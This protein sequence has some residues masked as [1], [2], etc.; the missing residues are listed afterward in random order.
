MPKVK[1][2]TAAGEIIA[3]LRADF[4]PRT[5]EAILSFLPMQYE[6]ML[7]CWGEEIFFFLPDSL[8]HIDYENAKTELEIGDVAYWPRDPA[9]C[10]FFGRTPLSKGSKPVAAGPVNVIGKV[11]EGMEIL[12]KLEDGDLI[13][14]EKKEE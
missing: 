10:I 1:F 13:F 11:I 5:V 9:C 2:T 6:V 3:E 4:A 14:M 7:Q 8:I 12:F